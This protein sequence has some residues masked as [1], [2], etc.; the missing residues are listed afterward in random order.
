MVQLKFKEGFQNS[1]LVKSATLGLFIGGLGMWLVLHGAVQTVLSLEFFQETHTPVLVTGV[2]ELTLTESNPTRLKIPSVGMNTTFRGPLGLEK[3]GS[4]SVPDSYTEIGWY[5]YGPTPGERG[6][7]VVLG[8]VDSLTGPAVFYPLKQV[9]IGDEIFIDREDGLT[10]VFEV[11]DI[12]NLSQNEFPT[13]RV[14]GNLAY[15]GLR[16]ITCTGTYDKKVLKYSHNLI[17]YAK[18]VRVA[19]TDHE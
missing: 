3:D 1:R 10:A 11:F 2:Q 12:E 6:P 18:L 8:H 17:V 7:S 15:A 5:E 16:L 4:V 14:Y 19:S 13:E 9:E